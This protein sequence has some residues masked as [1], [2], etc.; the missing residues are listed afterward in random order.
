MSVSMLIEL[1]HSFDRAKQGE[2]IFLIMGSLA[3]SVRLRV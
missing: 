3:K 2:E 1:D